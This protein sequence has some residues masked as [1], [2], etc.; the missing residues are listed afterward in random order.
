[1]E[2]N[3]TAASLLGLPHRALIKHPISQFIYREDQ[4]L[5]YRHLKR[6]RETGEPQAC[7]VRMVK[8][9]GKPFW[10]HLAASAAQDADGA[11]VARV[12]L[13]DITNRKQ[14]ELYRELGREI[15][16]ILAESGPL[17]GAIQRVLAVLKARTESD[18]VGIRLQDG[19]DFPYFTQE[20]FSKDFLLTE[21]T[22]VVRNAAGGIC[23][24]ADGSVCLECTCGLVISGKT[25][26]ANPF[27]T[28][29]GSCWTNDSIPL[30]DFLASEDLRLHPR[31]RC[32]HDGYAS[33]ALVPIR[34]KA[35]VVGLIQLNDRRKG[36]F[37]LEMV[38]SLEGIAEHIGEALMRRQAEDALQ[39]AHDELEQRVAE[40][41]GELRQANEKLQT[42]ITER[43]QA[44]AILQARLRISDYSFGHS[45]D[46][47]LT[48]TLD[49]GELLTGSAIGFFHFVEADQITL[50]LQTWST[51]TLRHMCTAEG[52]GRHYPADM[53]GV[54]VDA[55]RE[56]RTVVHND[57]A[58]LP[59][60]K[61]LPP[62]HAPVLRQ[63]V[64]PVLRNGQVVALLGVGNKA[65][66]YESA[67]IESV[68][69]LAD[70][71]WDIVVSKRAQA[72]SEKNRQLLVETE[73]G[74]KVGGW[75]FAIAT[76]KQTW[77]EETCR[78]HEVVLPYEPTVEKGVNFYA[79]SSRPM[80]ER[81]VRQTMERGEPFDLELEIITAKGNLR[82]VHVSGKA[83]PEHNRVYGFIQD[84]TARKQA[85]AEKEKLEE[86]NRQLQKSESLGR[87]AGAIA[88][89]FNNQLQAVMLSLEMATSNL[90]RNA[91]PI[92]GLSEAMQSARKAAEVSTLM[93]TYLGHSQGKHEPLDLAEVCRRSLVL[94]RAALPRSVVWETDLPAPGPGIRAN[95]SQV[96]QVLTNLVS[97]ASEASG[98]G[99]GVIRLSVKTV[100]VADIP[101]ARRF[102][103]DYRPQQKTYA[104]LEVADA[105]CGVAAKD[106][107]KLFDPFF[108]TKF[109]GRGL[110]LP[111]VL[112]IAR[113][114]D[115][116]VTVESE[117]GRGS[118]FR[119][120]F[121]MSAEAVP[122]KPVHVQGGPSPENV[123]RGATV[124]VVEDEPAVRKTLALVLKRSGFS[125]FEAEDGV[126]AVAVFQQHRNE[127]NC[128]VCDLTMP[129]MNGW[130]T[131]A[132]LRKL[133]PSIPVI[134]ASGYSEAEVMEGDHPERPQAFLHKPYESKV[135]INAIN[136]VL[137]SSVLE[138][139]NSL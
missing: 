98:D 26:P 138:L 95:A 57:Y 9:D 25:D 40:R 67:D 117:S 109:T 80:L 45:L 41:T 16:Q 102:P 74:G 68:S 73:R 23:R 20:G 22:L 69:R 48:R 44:E 72:A 119:V 56:R 113:S 43:R 137:A 46:E 115:G 75:E 103:I 107:D 64:V 111:V 118:T 3:L 76:G 27:F 35:S 99:R 77:T 79:P 62:G 104:C 86:Q 58:S 135:L 32:I 5:Y 90:P 131:L 82:S 10:A 81:A 124:L 65:C 96:Q 110:G 114:H 34:N 88:H 63:L 61:G 128:V 71:T 28:R 136:Q 100:A 13:S 60:R 127:I 4:N 52:K 83:D 108:S 93:L 17:P 92:D 19:D 18:A 36:R 42:E 94:L 105:G 97:N 116:V 78:I 129:R 47:L 139:P 8:Q 132:A 38:E 14:A 89:H 84:I 24:N 85:E 66:K 51:N 125:V 37:T 6:L 59:H 1:M 55:L 70:L 33:V 2:A 120:F 39:R 7:D 121:P 50:S 15:L 123:R 133:V 126:V 11:S 49:E 101:T 54:W 21:N 91:E 12:T 31:N 130:E 29:G 106:I 112:G 30:G 53:A 122:Q 87:M 134:L